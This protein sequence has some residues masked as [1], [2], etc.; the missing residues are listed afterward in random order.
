MRAKKGGN[1]DKAPS[2]VDG[3]LS[4]STALAKKGLPRNHQLWLRIQSR[5]KKKKES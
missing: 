4:F 2:L 1:T 3:A 5:W